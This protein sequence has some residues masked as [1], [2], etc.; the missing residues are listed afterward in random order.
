LEAE[1]FAPAHNAETPLAERRILV[2]DDQP[3]V[4]G[5]LE[6]AL[7]EA[8]AHV[9]TAEDG[10]S[11]LRSAHASHPDLILLDLAMPGMDGWQVLDALGASPR[12]AS[13]PVVLETSSEDEKSFERARKQGV[14]AFITKPFRLTEILE[15]CCRILDGGRRMLT[16]DQPS[17]PRFRGEVRGYDGR[18]LGS[19]ALLALADRTAEI[20]LDLPLL[21]GQAV[22]LLLEGET[23]PRV[24]EVRWVY[25]VGGRFQ[26]GLALA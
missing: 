13:I 19:G 22:K 9:W 6:L 16:G 2:V 20:E 1:L 17:R 26:H 15:T 8:G 7:A 25:C 5:M 24:A 14:A 11:A 10:K 3:S 12:T 23:D 18:L 4:R 21:P